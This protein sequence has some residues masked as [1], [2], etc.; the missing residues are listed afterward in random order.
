MT[1][2]VQAALIKNA[3]NNGN[4]TL[5]AKLAILANIEQGS[6]GVFV[7]NAY[8]DVEQYMTRK[9]WAGCLSQLQKQGFYSPSQDPEYKGH[10]G[11]IVN[12][13]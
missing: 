7:D 12:K 13:E 5:A 9:Q 8:S 1:S 4:L 3:A 11:Y 2:K 6:N 10:Y